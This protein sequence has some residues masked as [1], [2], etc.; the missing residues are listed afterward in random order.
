MC[1]S[2]GRAPEECP[3]SFLGRPAPAGMD[4][5]VVSIPAHSQLVY[6]A[7]EW[8]GALVIVEAGEIEVECRRGTSACFA[9]GSVLFFDGLGLR[10]VRNRCGKTVL[11][12]AVSRRRTHEPAKESSMRWLPFS[13]HR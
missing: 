4:L 11:L 3:V 12:C 10:A 9:A 5:R 8:A 2:T 6:E 7:V 13:I 1:P